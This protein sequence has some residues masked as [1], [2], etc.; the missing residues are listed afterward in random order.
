MRAYFIEIKNRLF[1]ILASQT[2][3]FLVL[4]YYK[5]ILLF[6]TVYPILK[7]KTPVS[8][9]IVND[10]MELF[11]VYFY[12]ILFINKQ[13]IVLSFFYHFFV[14]TAPAWY[15]SEFQSLTL[16]GKVIFCLWISSNLATNV[17][18]IPVTWLFFLDF[19]NTEYGLF[20]NV[21]FE[22]RLIDYLHFYVVFYW[23][24]FW[25][26]QLAGL[27]FFS[28]SLPLV[29]L[30]FIKK[31]RKFFYFG[32]FLIAA[33]VCSDIFSQLFFIMILLLTYEL[34]LIGKLMSFR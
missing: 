33:V 7:L 29:S 16:A 22:P 25:Y 14:F 26:C 34:S 3:S 31:Y 21:Y 28:L 17:I 11:S 1:L 12:I 27:I 32:F 4:Y 6:I 10:V 15:K 8:Y 23:V 18:F 19:N 9:F 30:T 2:C 24:N 13:L 20:F 5:N